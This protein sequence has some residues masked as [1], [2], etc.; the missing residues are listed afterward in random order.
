MDNY[1]KKW[2]DILN[3]MSNDNT[4]KLAWGRAI[5][6]AIVFDEGVINGNHYRIHFDTISAHML[7][8]YWNQCFF[9][10]LK[11]SSNQAHP[12]VV[13]QLT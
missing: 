10:N 9:F 3:G 4:Y 12:P 2:F 7:K 13:V 5:I 8:Y 1:F 11:Q 6:E